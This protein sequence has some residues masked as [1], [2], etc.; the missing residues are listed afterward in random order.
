MVLAWLALGLLAMLV[1]SPAVFLGKATRCHRGLSLLVHQ[2]ECGIIACEEERCNE[3]HDNVWADDIPV[4]WVSVRRINETSGPLFDTVKS[5]GTRV[6]Y[7]YIDDRMEKNR[8]LEQAVL[9]AT[10][11][12]WYAPS[13]VGYRPGKP[14]R[15]T[16]VWSGVL[17]NAALVFAVS[18]FCF[19][20]VTR[21]Q[22][23][24][25]LERLKLGRCPI[26]KYSIEGLPTDRCPE[27]GSLV[28]TPEHSDSE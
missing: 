28:R 19:G 20:F 23:S 16:I 13:L 12:S 26:C 5:H 14:V 11:Q 21:G 15:K 22:R 2:A 6:R 24:V 17:M 3:I 4:A 8:E 1:L 25:R 9:G 7:H 27:C 18:A 10:L